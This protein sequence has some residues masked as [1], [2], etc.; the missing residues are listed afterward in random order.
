MR[1]CDVCQKTL[2]VFNKRGFLYGP[3][4]PI[5]GFGGVA[6]TLL[7]SNFMKTI[8]NVSLV[9]SIW[10]STIVIMFIWGT[11]EYISSWLMENLFHA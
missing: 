5:Y 6:I 10:I 3:V 4:C 11:F 8:D 9:D 2:G 7:L 1:T